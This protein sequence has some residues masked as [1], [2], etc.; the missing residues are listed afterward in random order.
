MQYH[1]VQC[2]F[3]SK[4]NSW[5]SYTIELCHMT[6]NINLCENRN[7]KKKFFSTIK[8]LL[9]KAI[10]YNNYLPI[11]PKVTSIE[12]F[13]ELSTDLLANYPTTTTLSTTYTN[14]SKK[15]K[16]STSESAATS[17]PKSN[18]IS[19]HAVSFKLYEPNSGKCI[20]YTTTKSKELSRLLNF[21][22][23]KGLTND[24]LHVV[25]LASLMTNVKYEKPIEPS[26]ENTPIPESENLATKEIEQNKPDAKEEKTTTT[27]S[28]KKKNKKKKKKN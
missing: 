17:K 11:M 23:P 20:R 28:S 6:S 10:I 26:L 27:T 22:G 9:T 4:T 24:N 15:S 16:K 2:L 7:G 3:D 8:N 14:V 21:I 1:Y 19:T 18:K 13:I 5:G 25:G 12:K